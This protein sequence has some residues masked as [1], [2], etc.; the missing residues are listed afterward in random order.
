MAMANECDCRLSTH[1]Q[2]PSAAGCRIFAPKPCELVAMKSIKPHSRIRRFR[3][4]AVYILLITAAAI[5]A[6]VFFE[7]HAP[8]VGRYMISSGQAERPSDA[9]RI[10]R[11]GDAWNSSPRASTP[12]APASQRPAAAPGAQLI[13]VVTR[14]RDGDTIVVGLIPIRIAN[15][16]CAETG[17]AAG[18]RAT[19]RM[20]ELVRGQQLTC[21]LEGRRSWDR[22]VGV[23]AL[24]GGRDLGEILIAERFCT[25]WR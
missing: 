4:E 11:G 8:S 18:E 16:D 23:C 20:T 3:R 25:R 12:R 22:E 17:T 2:S 5:G 7:P 13:D 9:P 6:L 19:R 24:P 21:Q 10:I 15:L 1:Q 14:V